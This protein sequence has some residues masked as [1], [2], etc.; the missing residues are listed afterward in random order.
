[1]ELESFGADVEF[2]P[3]HVKKEKITVQ[4]PLWKDI[5]SLDF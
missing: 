2:I 1:M 3:A 4:I 5:Y